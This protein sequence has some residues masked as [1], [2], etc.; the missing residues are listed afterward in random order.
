MAVAQGYGKTVTSGSVFAYDTGDI[1]NSYLGRPTTN[2][3]T[4]PLYI[5]N[6]VSGNVSSTL[7]ATSET[8]KGATV[9]RQ[10]LT[11]LDAS[12]ASW[13]SNGNNPGIGV[14]TW[15]GGGGNANTY[16][17]HSIFFK[18]NFLLFS[19]PI[20]LHYSNIAGY[21]ACCTLPEDMGDGWFRA[22][23]IW[24]D[25]VTRS[26]GK[27][28]AINPLSTAIGQTITIDWAGPFREDLN[29]TSVSQFVN[30][31]RSATQGLLP[32][33]G[34]ATLNLS[35]VSFTTPAINPQMTFDGTDDFI[36]LSPG[37]IP[38]SQVSFEFICTNTNSGA[39]T[40]II[41]GGVGDGGQDLNIHLP[42]GDG[43]VYW[44]FGRPFNR[45]NKL[46]TSAERIGIHHWIFTKNSTT[47]IMNIYLDGTLWHTG[48]GLTTTLPAIT[49]AS[50]GRYDRGDFT[51]FHYRG[52]IPVFKIYDKALSAAEVRQNYQHYKTRFNLS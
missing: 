37:I 41:A 45:I 7:T 33:I 21:Q 39:S 18:P 26:D 25:T 52:T 29:S 28:W 16:T 35:N 5:Y 44:D 34:N 42:W 3:N 24:F 4:H 15:P 32:L 10:T 40:S 6:N 31:T 22:Y 20:F 49:A 43:N 38:T 23:V 13:L 30:G 17:G 48:S 47:G 8:Y 1:R 50:L 9:L 46:T 14:Y 12:G 51:G 27:F 19:T 11:P 36:P 2:T